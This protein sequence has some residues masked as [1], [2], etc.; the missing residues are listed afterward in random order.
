MK[1]LLFLGLLLSS[2]VFAS[3]DDDTT[4]PKDA[5]PAPQNSAKVPLDP[6]AMVKV[7]IEGVVL[8]QDC[9]SRGT[10]S[11]LNSKPIKGAKVSVT[12]RDRKN[13]PVGF[14]AVE[15]DDNGYFYCPFD[16]D[17]M[18]DY[19]D[20]DPTRACFVRLLSSPDKGCNALTNINWGIIG[21]PV[22][23]A[24][25]LFTSPD[26]T[27]VVLETGALAFRPGWCTISG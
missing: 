3:A 23:F 10:W 16:V 12:C 4:V 11:L 6:N 27:T 20:S 1:A 8:C 2:A 7:V 19:F 18:D 25:K 5:P 13:R 15:T 22:N 17:R 26:Y 24:G 14:Y 21:A 9:S